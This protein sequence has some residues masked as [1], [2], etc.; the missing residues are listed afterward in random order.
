MFDDSR[1]SSDDRSPAYRETGIDLRA[2]PEEG[3]SLGVN[4]A[5]NGHQ[6][7]QGHVV[8]QDG[9]MPDRAVDIDMN[10]PAQRDVVR[11]GDIGTDHRSWPHRDVAPT[12]NRGRVHEDR[13]WPI[14]LS[15]DLVEL[16]SNNR[17]AH[18]NYVADIAV[19][20]TQRGDTPEVPKSI[21]GE[22]GL[23]RLPVVEESNDIQHGSGG[24]EI[25]GLNNIDNFSPVAACP[26]NDES[27][28]HGATFAETGHRSQN[29]TH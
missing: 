1:T 22:E 12:H 18:R 3:L 13:R 11:D 23:V 19:E 16:G 7:G 26:D 25:D 17:V 20:F 28:N 24:V 29:R 15:T 2:G 21:W 8:V 4:V 10:V 9:V 5:G 27:L 6:G 14:E